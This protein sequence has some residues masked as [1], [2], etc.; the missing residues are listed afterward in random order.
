MQIIYSLTHIVKK[1]RVSQ[2]NVYSIYKVKEINE[3]K[4]SYL[5]H[6]IYYF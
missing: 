2:K 5:Q 3:I 6:L 4:R 1:Y